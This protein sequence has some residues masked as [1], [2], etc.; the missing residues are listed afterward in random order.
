MSISSVFKENV[1]LSVRSSPY[2][3]DIFLFSMEIREPR[4]IGFKLSFK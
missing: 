2:F 3:I 4:A 1:I